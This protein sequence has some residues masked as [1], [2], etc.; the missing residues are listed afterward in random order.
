MKKITI[1]VMVLTLGIFNT[2]TLEAVQW[3]YE[4][5]GVVDQFVGTTDVL[6]IDGQSATLLLTV[7][8]TPDTWG[9]SPLT[10]S[11]AEFDLTDA[12]FTI[13]TNTYNATNSGSLIRLYNYFT[14]N[15]VPGGD[16]D[17]FEFDIR[18]FQIPDSSNTMYDVDVLGRVN[19]NSLAFW[20]DSEVPPAHKAFDASV[21]DDITVDFGDSPGDPG[22]YGYTFIQAEAI[23]A[24]VPEPTT[25]LLIGSG[26]IGLAGFRRKLRKE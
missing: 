15:T 18:N 6:G 5:T 13:G 11:W 25:M 16:Y 19:F 9:S 14:T 2:S 8:D 24:P 3:T 17:F 4:I 22:V 20:T 1:L 7:G 12:A 26:L 10:F 21:V 23:A